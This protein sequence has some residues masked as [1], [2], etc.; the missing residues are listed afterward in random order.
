MIKKAAPLAGWPVKVREA[1]LL[2][3]TEGGWGVEGGPY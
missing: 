1:A 3:D 2:C